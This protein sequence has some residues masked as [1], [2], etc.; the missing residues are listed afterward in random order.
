[1]AMKKKKMKIR[2]FH[3]PNM[4]N[5]CS[6]LWLDI[7]DNNFPIVKMSVVVYVVQP[8]HMI[9]SPLK[10]ACCCSS[11]GHT[12]H[13]WWLGSS[14]AAPWPEQPEH[15]CH[16]KTGFLFSAIAP[17]V[18]ALFHLVLKGEQPPNFKE[19]TGCAPCCSG[20]KFDSG[21][22]SMNLEGN[23]CKIRSRAGHV[24]MHATFTIG[25]IKKIEKMP[26]I[27]DHDGQFLAPVPTV[28]SSRIPFRFYGLIIGMTTHNYFKHVLGW[29]N[30][31]KK[32]VAGFNW[33][34]SSSILLHQVA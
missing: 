6:F 31:R 23:G 27:S 22:I 33:Q 34:P 10:L 25:F 16:K 8:K 3:C 13:Q 32:E 5:N 12:F 18:A 1:M 24:M 11:P 20:E 7:L 26:A 28:T 4:G 15:F 17:K 29:D 30:K 19:T 9:S 21:N 14:S 2:R